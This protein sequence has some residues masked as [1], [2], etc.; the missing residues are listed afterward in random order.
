MSLKLRRLKVLC[1][2][3]SN[4]GNSTNLPSRKDGRSNMT[5]NFYLD[6][7][8]L[9]KLSTDPD[10]KVRQAVADQ[11]SAPQQDA[12]SLKAV[13]EGTKIVPQS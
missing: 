7:Y 9:A 5:H 13:V 10:L 4:G 6:Q 1:I 8:I 3:S 11:Y 12:G 2:G